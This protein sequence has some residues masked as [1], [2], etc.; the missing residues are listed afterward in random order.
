[1][2]PTAQPVGW[3]EFFTRP[4]AR[5]HLAC[6]RIMRPRTRRLRSAGLSVNGGVAPTWSAR[7]DELFVVA[8]GTRMVASVTAVPACNIGVPN[9]LCPAA[10]VGAS[11]IDDDVAADGKRFVVVRT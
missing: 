7:G 6:Q 11:A 10:N 1:M 4:N 2:V 5:E 8:N 9:A 3:V